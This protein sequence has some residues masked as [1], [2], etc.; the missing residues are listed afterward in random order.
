LELSIVISA[1]LFVG[2]CSDLTTTRS[3]QTNAASLV[4]PPTTI[5]AVAHL[6]TVPSTDAATIGG[7]IAA[8]GG[9]LQLTFS[10]DDQTCLTTALTKGINPTT[11]S[12][13][14][15]DP[16]FFD[17]A[18]VDR[19]PVLA[20]FDPCVPV[21]EYV[22]QLSPKLRA[23][24]ASKTA[25]T[26]AYTKLH[27]LGFTRLVEYAHG[28]TSDEGPDPT[29]AET[30]AKIFKECGVKTDTTAPPAADSGAPASTSPG[31]TEA[32]DPSAGPADTTTS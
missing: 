27:A 6:E 23:A 31:A 25:T 9:L 26:C 14:R 8:V 21:D 24:G 12:A 4:V 1:V 28:L 19:A 20:L 18:P 32:P 11:M 29:V 5:D 22:G 7:V 16:E 15:R 30:V 3:T 13:L 17:I 2:G 10:D